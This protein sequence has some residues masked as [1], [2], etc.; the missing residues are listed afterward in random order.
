[1]K[2]YF[3]LKL[4][5]YGLLALFSA[6]IA[7]QGESR[8]PLRMIDRPGIVPTGIINVDI[9]SKLKFVKV[10]GTE[11]KVKSVDMGFSST[12]G[13]VKGLQGS[14]GYEGFHFNHL[15]EGKTETTGFSAGKSLSLSAKYNYLA[16]PGFSA[17]VSAKLPIYFTDH[18]IRDFTVGV[19]VTFYNSFL[20]FGGL[21][22]LFTL[23]MRKDI[24]AKLDFA[25]WFGVQ[26]YGN[27]WAELNTSFGN[28]YF[29][30]KDGQDK[31]IGTGFWKSLP[32]DVSLLY[33]LNPYMDI[34]ASA[35]FGNAIKAENFNI[36]L[37]I[38]LRAGQLFS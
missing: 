20:A 18:I 30:N 16:L 31:M 33:G 8:Y 7:A 34:S 36:G 15:E 26:V 28:I 10:P 6:N 25:A 3:S 27:F 11:N 9:D 19:P 5:S 22:D 38:T 14:F 17:Y 13:I 2:N 29:P 12:F 32:V 37:K 35:G 24:S 23:T 1:M 4:K 21:G